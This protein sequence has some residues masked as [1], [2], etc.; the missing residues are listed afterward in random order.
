MKNL[1]IA[2][3]ELGHVYY[4]LLYKDQPSV[5]RD[6]ANPGMHFHTTHFSWLQIS[7]ILK[8]KIPFDLHSGFHEAVGDVFALSAM[9]PKH[10]EKLGVL[11][12]YTHDEEAKI[13]EI[14]QSALTKIVLLPF[15]YSLDQYRWEL[16]RG[17]IES[18]EYNCRFWQIREE[19]SG[20]VPPI[21]RFKEDFDPPA[22]FHI[23]ADV[24]YLRFVHVYNRK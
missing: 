5:Y 6:G 3:H 9:T 2:F 21:Q 11:K 8:L 14:Y 16:F 13:N 23:S 4:Y 24:E 1:R 7:F 12:N 17:E 22:K 20:I 10:L 18:D 15:A 19:A